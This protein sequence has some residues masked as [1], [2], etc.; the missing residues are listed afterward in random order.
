M[1]TSTAVDDGSAP[2]QGR[3]WGSRARDWADV[4]EGLV[5]PLYEAVLDRFAV[6]AGTAL[7][8]VGCG[9]GMFCA[10]AAARGARVA[11]L[12]AA[13]PSIAIALERVPA[14]DFQVGEMEA[15]PFADRSFEL[16][17][18]FNS[19]QYAANPTRALVEARRVAKP[20]G[21]V[22]IALWGEAD[23]CEAATYFA[24]MAPL[25]PPPPPGAP[26][27]FALSPRGALEGLARGAGLTPVEVED[28]ACP[29]VY[30]DAETAIRGLISA[31][32]AVRAIETS[33]E[34]R[35]REAVGGAL[36]QFRDAHGGYR[37]ENTFRYLVA[38]P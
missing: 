21:H 10:M 32:P 29:W 11:G 4:Q 18:G 20:S 37:L 19:F 2:V 36:E 16:V 3:L 1:T 14:G 5:R 33:G 13:A 28:V 35:V 12:D 30:P 8:D 25:L 6:G 26:G 15:L 17:T 27:P 9:A 23:T 7:L 34:E 38:T 31:G 22:V 24:A